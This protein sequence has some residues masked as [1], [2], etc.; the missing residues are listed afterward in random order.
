MLNATNKEVA[1]NLNAF[2]LILEVKSISVIRLRN[3]F[4]FGILETV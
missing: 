1:N 4:F 2:M 3:K